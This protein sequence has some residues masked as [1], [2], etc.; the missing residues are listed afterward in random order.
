MDGTSFEPDPLLSEHND[1]LYPSR[2]LD[3]TVVS[4]LEEYSAALDTIRRK[5]RLR[6]ACSNLHLSVPKSANLER[7]RSAL[8]LYWFP[9]DSSADT[10]PTTINT[11]NEATEN[12]ADIK[13]QHLSAQSHN[14]ID[15]GALISH[16]SV[17]GAAADEILGY[18][19][20]NELLDEDDEFG[21]D[22][23]NNEDDI[24]DTSD[25]FEQFVTQTRV[26]E[27]KRSE[28]NRRAGGVKTQS[29]V[30]RDWK[31]FCR[32]ALDKGEIQDDIVDCHHL[33]LYIRHS[34]ERPKRT[35]KG[36]DIPGTYLGASQLKKLYFGALRIRKMQEALD[37]T[38]EKTRPAKSIHVWDCI[39]GRMNEALNRSRNG[40]IPGEDAPDIV[41][42]TFLASVTEE[43]MAK[44]GGGFLM[45]REYNSL[46]VELDEIFQVRS[47]INGHLAWAAQNASGNRGDDFRALKLAELQP[48]VFLHPNKE[49]AVECVLGLQGEEKAAANR[50]L[51][52]KVNPVYTVFIAHKDPTICP[53]GAFAFY[54]HFIHDVKKLTEE[55]DVDWSI[56]KSWR[57]VRVLHG[58]TSPTT[59]YH[60]QSLYNLYVKAFSQANFISKIKAHLPRHIL[61]YSQEKMGVDG[62]HTSRLGWVRGETY[63]DTY[64]PAIPKEAVLGAHGYKTHEVY[65]PLWR[66]V[67]V[68]EAF[69]NLVCPI[70]EDIH[71]KIVG[72]ANLSGAANYWAMCGAA[73]YQKYPESALFRLPA[74]ANPQVQH[75][76]KTEYPTSLAHLQANAGSTVD[77]ER[78]QNNLLRLSLE[79]M[80]ALLATQ[81]AELKEMRLLIQRRTDVLSPTKGFSNLSYQHSLNVSKVPQPVFTLAVPESP[82]ANKSAGHS[83]TKNSDDTG[84][85][86]LNAPNDSKQPGSPL[87]AFANGSPKVSSESRSR[88]QVDLVLPHV[89]AFSN[90]GGPQLFWPPVLGQKSVTWEQVFRL[91]KRPELLWDAW[92]PSKTLNKYTLN[93]QWTCYNSGEPV[94]NASGT[95]T[96]IK[97]PLQ[98]VELHFQSAWRTKPAARKA[99]QRFRKIPEFIHS[100]STLRGVSPQIVI[101]E[102][103]K[104]A[105]GGNGRVKGLSAITDEI[106]A[107]RIAKAQAS[108]DTIKEAESRIS[109]LS[110]ALDHRESSGKIAMKLGVDIST[111]MSE[112]VAALQ[113]P[114]ISGQFYGG[115]L[116]ILFMKMCE[117]IKYPLTLVFVYDGPG[118]PLIKRGTNVR[119]NQ[120]PFWTNPSKDII[121]AFG[122]HIHQAP[123]EAEA[124]LAM[125]NR[126]GLIDGII[127]NDSDVFVFGAQTVYR[128]IPTKER[129][130]EDEMIAYTY[131]HLLDLG[132][133]SGGLV[134]FALVCGGDYDCAGLKG[135][136]PSHAH[137][138]ASCGFGDQLVKAFQTLSGVALQ[139]FL[140]HWRTEIKHELLTNS[141]GHLHSRSPV[142][143]ERLTES[144]PDLDI[145]DL[146]LNP[147]TSAPG[148]KFQPWILQEPSVPGLI[149]VSS[150]HLGWRSEDV[151]RKRFKA[152][153][154]EGIFLQMLYSPLILYDSSRKLFATPNT[155]ALVLTCK[156]LKR[157]GCVQPNASELH[158]RLLVSAQ[159]F[160]TLMGFHSNQSNE[161]DQFR[162]WVPRSILPQELHTTVE[163]SQSVTRMKINPSRRRRPSSSSSTMEEQNN[164]IRHFEVIDL[165]DETEV[166]NIQSTSNV[167]DL[168]QD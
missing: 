97:P 63:F 111:L 81:A 146:Y 115:A 90:P 154:W 39:K 5:E 129:H 2:T 46:W 125:L 6:E 95:Q 9:L 99:W 153:V 41:A 16:F 20:D 21:E 137:A 79:E 54:H 62:V 10:A 51:H 149:D 33:L 120:S 19:E 60:E 43:Q 156:L 69:L 59:P 82:L 52:T 143:S 24:M 80:R 57:Q 76:M 44:I 166:S 88:T 140:N 7:L 12:Q 86:V 150:T 165:T 75:W 13:D 109:I 112:C 105:T 98:Q 65:D 102:L 28:K 161:V 72:R 121:R 130:F 103:E 14:I 117:F 78:I 73:I 107:Q 118:R 124:E 23:D 134:L 113:G 83:A 47:V 92:C 74:L 151:L 106:Y 67:H 108:K 68:P 34:A 152:K 114:T 84:I 110:T 8:K 91:I 30:V 168:T 58:K 96:G 4:T 32:Q 136:G 61:G 50:G 142:L 40:L 71:A 66:R 36:L 77:L 155:Q 158:A 157:K 138:L 37:P 17:E 70:A 133:T 148:Q 164:S 122:Y 144:F 22:L 48:Y 45:H 27:A 160:V 3:G 145:L 163:G 31:M 167:I 11:V 119:V 87:R 162:V 147:L 128:T 49:T 135:F 53:L 29:A 89:D 1:L 35:R 64:A 18:D 25:D 126:R 38:L 94:F 56:N 116:H 127:T 141:H 132:L 139:D 93:E 85:Y 101:E 100:E 42:N 26:D 131:S 15:D 123:G 104:S 55:L 159:N